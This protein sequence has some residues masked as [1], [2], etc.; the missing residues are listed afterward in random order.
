MQQDEI[1]V[2]LRSSEPAGDY[3][4]EVSLRITAYF[5]EDSSFDGNTLTFQCDPVGTNYRSSYLKVTF[6]DNEYE[7]FCELRSMRV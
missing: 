3:N 4:P 7:N 2:L 1:E 6:D 5:R